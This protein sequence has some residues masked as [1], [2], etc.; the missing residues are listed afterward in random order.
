MGRGGKRVVCLSCGVRVD[1]ELAIKTKSGYLCEDCSEAVE[2][3]T[4]DEE[5]EEDEEELYAEEK[6]LDLFED[7]EEDFS[8]IYDEED[9]DPNEEDY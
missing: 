6:E 3:E 5:E 4:Y 8:S 7:L 1:Q 2:E 9:F